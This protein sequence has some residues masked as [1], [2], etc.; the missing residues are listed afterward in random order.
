MAQLQLAMTAVTQWVTA[1]PELVASAVIVAV[2]LGIAWLIA[3][4]IAQGGITEATLDLARHQP[5]SFGRAWREGR[6]FFWRFVGLALIYLAI[7]AVTAAVIGAGVAAA[8]ATISLATGTAQGM[9]TGLW[10]TLGVIAALVAIPF[11]VGITI[12][13]AFAQRAIVAENTG[14]IEAIR[15]GWHL[16][17][18]HLGDSVLTWLVNLGLSIGA[19][20]A[21]AIATGIVAAVLVAVGVGLW[22]TLGL[23]TV[24]LIYAT[25]GIITTI[26]VLLTLVSI[27]NAF[28]WDYWTLAYLRLT[29]NQ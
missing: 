14:P 4:F 20:I 7:A 19:N 15:S 2:S 28:F 13:L 1:H 26:T 3:S 9:L 27:A 16:L 6:H 29:G 21:I 22:I 23:T 8:I 10:V 5:A 12:T 24:T 25:L 18:A 17:R 11:F